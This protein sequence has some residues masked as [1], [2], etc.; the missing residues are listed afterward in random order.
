LGASGIRGDEHPFDLLM[1]NE[2]P[3]EKWV[4]VILVF[5][6]LTAYVSSLFF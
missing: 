4:P 1:R 6:G 5:L 2:D 3:L